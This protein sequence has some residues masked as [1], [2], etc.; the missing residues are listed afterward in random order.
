MQSRSIDD[1][2]K[3]KLSKKITKTTQDKIIDE[4]KAKIENKIKK[5]S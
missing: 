1:E 5:I 2:S 4:R 3:L